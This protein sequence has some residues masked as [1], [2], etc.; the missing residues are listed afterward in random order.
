MNGMS[1]SKRDSQW[2]N[3]ALVV[4]V[5]PDDPVLEPYREKYGVMAGVEF[6]RDMERR[7]AVLGGGLNLTVPVQR[8]T[9]FIEGKVSET[10]PSSSYRLGVR[11][12]ACHEIY[13]APITAALRDALV[14]HF[15]AQMPGYVHPDG[16]LH[17][18][19]TRTSSPLRMA[20]EAE[21]LQAKGLTNLFPA[22]EGAGK[23]YVMFTFHTY[24]RRCDLLGRSKIRN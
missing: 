11:S 12:A 2:A 1:F 7:A 4:T 6:Q 19:E 22:G 13:P 20:R 10:I 21:T 9:D 23:S 24:S 16:L 15:D 17:G 3:S 18:V 5:F 8:V 14:N